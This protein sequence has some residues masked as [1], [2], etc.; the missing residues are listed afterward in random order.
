MTEHEPTDIPA[1]IAELDALI[2]TDHEGGAH[3][4]RYRRVRAA[5]AEQSQQREAAEQIAKVNYGLYKSAESDLSAAE[6]ALAT[7]RADALEETAQP[8]VPDQGIRDQVAEVLRGAYSC[9]RAWEAWSYGTMT[10][11]DFAPAWEDEDLIDGLTALAAGYSP[12][13]PTLADTPEIFP[14]TLDQLDALSCRAAATTEGTG[15]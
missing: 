4:Q 2:P 8:S 11:D 5:L 13:S 14:G 3:A 15:Q 7:A 12:K 6:V 1:L 10:E 9:T